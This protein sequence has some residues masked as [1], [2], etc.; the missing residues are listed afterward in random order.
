MYRKFSGASTNVKRYTVQASIAPVAELEIE[1]P[2]AKQNISFQIE[3]APFTVANLVEF[4]QVFLF[5]GGLFIGFFTL[6]GFTSKTFPV[7]RSVL[8][9][10]ETR[11][12]LVIPTAISPKRL[13]LGDDEHE[14]GIYISSMLFSSG[15]PAKEVEAKPSTRAK[16]TS[17]N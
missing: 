17:A 3:A 7:T 13:K 8:S 9:G 11:V 4:Q 10:R 2:F 15:S 1:L 5:V 6:H 14:L 16:V 12:T